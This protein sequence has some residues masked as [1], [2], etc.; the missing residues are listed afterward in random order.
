MTRLLT[1]TGAGGSGKTRLA[2]QV[3]AKAS[4]DYA[5]G[6]HFV[7]LA[8]ITEP[9]LVVS[10]IAQ[11]L[12]V[13][14]QGSR[15]LLGSLK[16]QLQDKQVLLL[17]DNFEQIV[18]AAPIV[19]ELLVTA[20]RLKVLVTSRAS[21]HLSGEHE[22]VVPPLSLLKLVVTQSIWSSGSDIKPSNE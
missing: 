18:S 21:L 22:F 6:V 7:S 14:E 17:L 12:G 19:T 9:G 5:N 11:A 8:P 2:V 15:P 20:P 1:L 16:D 10:T 3:A 13:R 4:S